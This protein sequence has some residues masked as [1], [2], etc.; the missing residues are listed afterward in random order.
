MSCPAIAK[1]RH[2]FC[3][4]TAGCSKIRVGMLNIKTVL[5]VQCWPTCALIAGPFVPPETP[6]WTVPDQRVCACCCSAAAVAGP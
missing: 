3:S 2:L 5:A 6:I 4:T 1:A